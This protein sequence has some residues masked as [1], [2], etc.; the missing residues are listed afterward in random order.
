M[1]V[2]YS[3]EEP[4]VSLRW[5]S[6]KLQ[7]KWVVQRSDGVTVHEWRDVPNAAGDK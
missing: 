5:N 3:D 1:A 7:Q 4:T 6:G 2:K